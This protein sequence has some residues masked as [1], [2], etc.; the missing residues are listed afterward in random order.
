MEETPGPSPCPLHCD[1]SVT[2][3]TSDLG[4]P[5][6][7][8]QFCSPIPTKTPRPTHRRRCQGAPHAP[9]SRRSA[10]VQ[11]R[12]RSCCHPLPQQPP[13]PAQPSKLL[14]DWTRQAS[15]ATARQGRLVEKNLVFRN[16]SDTLFH[17]GQP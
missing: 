12:A 5:P 10:P 14:D 7:P 16:S 3:R 15:I 13:S 2:A 1:P 17:Q 4:A 9:P 8:C 6:N 11:P